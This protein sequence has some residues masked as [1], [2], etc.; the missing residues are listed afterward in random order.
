MEQLN[1]PELVEEVVGVFRHLSQG[2][3]KEMM[4]ALM[5]IDLSMAQLRTLFVMARQEPIT[6]GQVAEK[7]G[8]GIPTASHLVEKLVQA[9]LAERAEDPADRR[10]TMVRLTES[11]L[12]LARRLGHG[13]EELF[14][15]LL[16]Q[17]SDEELSAIIVGLGALLRVTEK[18]LNNRQKDVV[19]LVR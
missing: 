8:I 14:R 13:R 15:T 18:E 3:Q 7:L 6:I 2:W 19:G 9:E 1:K 10:R 11:G 4:A 16:F 5:E 17:L 12:T